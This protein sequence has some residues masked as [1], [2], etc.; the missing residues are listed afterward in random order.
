MDYL[1]KA[2]NGCYSDVIARPGEVEVI[3][4]GVPCTGFSNLNQRRGDDN[5][6]RS[7]SL[8][9]LFAAY[10]DFYRSKYAILEN[11]PNVAECSPK[12]KNKM[13]SRK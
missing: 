2:M 11:V 9:A 13:F 12:N 7:N 6:L 4:G 3:A 5:A 8:I 1:C 10:V